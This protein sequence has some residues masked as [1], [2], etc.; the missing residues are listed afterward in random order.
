[1]AGSRRFGRR[2]VSASFGAV[3]LPGL[4]S[5]NSSATIMTIPADI[6]ALI[7]RQLGAALADAWRRQQSVNDERQ[8]PSMVAVSDVR[9]DGETTRPAGSGQA[10]VRDDGGR[11]DG[12]KH[13]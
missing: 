6:R 9:S 12:E 8:D 11:N 3:T 2:L 1:M 13:C 4:S 10:R 5:M 7:V